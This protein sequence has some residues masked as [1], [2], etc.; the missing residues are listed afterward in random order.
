MTHEPVLISTI[1]IGLTA[2]FVG[3]LVARRLGLPAIVGYLIAGMAIGPFTPGLVADEEIATELAEI[4]VILLMFGVGI[5]F[6]FRDLLAV[7]SIAVPG[8]IGQV[9]VATLL[10]VL[11]GVAL[12]WGLGGGIVLGLAVS[13]AS[14]VVLLRALMERNELDT[15]QGRIAVGWL[16]VED[17]FTVIVLILL[18]TVAPLLGG[19]AAA[20]TPGQFGPLGEV[21]LALAKA[22]IFALLMGIFGIRVVPWLLGVVAREGSRELFTLAVLALALG[23]AFASSAIFG[24]SFALGAFLAGA[25]VSESDMSHQ[26][27]A[28]ALPLRDAFAVLFFVSVGML[29]DPSFLLAQPLAIVAMVGLIVGVKWLTKFV[30]VA[31]FGY[32]LRTGLTVAAGLAQ[33]GEFSFILASLGLSLGLLPME[34][35]QLLVAGALLS[36]TINPLL[37]GAIAPVE[38]LLRRRPALARLLERRAGTLAS[39][40][41]DTGDELRGHAILCGYGRVGRM[42]SSALERRGFRYVVVTLDRREVESLREGGVPA[43]Y[44]DASNPELLEQAGIHEARTVIVAISDPHATRLVVERARAANERISLVVRTHS[45]AEVSHLQTVSGN[46]QAVHG[47]REL[48]VQMTRYALR[49]FGVSAA[50]AEAIAQGLRRRASGEPH[51]D[52]RPRSGGGRSLISRLIRRS[53]RVASRGAMKRTADEGMPHDQGTLPPPQDAVTTKAA[54]SR[55]TIARP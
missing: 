48:A 15:T 42:I 5:H 8:A 47:G 19:D 1:A 7:R 52:T 2:A 46:I 53:R 4:G 39:L 12:G 45:D 17:I 9:A 14:T 36:I 32:P 30:I 21:V 41:R 35:F 20:G 38:A 23:I 55:D 50:E 6:S 27:A 31:A 11:L 16:I 24:V 28:D 13:V 34:G 43:L 37:F 29:L 25:V 3:G 33:I 10:G 54:V 40:E 51:I 18:P 49:R 26:A 22:G 44:G